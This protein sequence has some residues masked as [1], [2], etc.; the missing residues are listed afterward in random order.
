MKTYRYDHDG[1]PIAHEPPA[2]DGT[3]SLLRAVPRFW[4]RGHFVCERCSLIFIGILEM[5]RR[6]RPPMRM[7]CPGCGGTSAVPEA[8]WKASAK[9]SC[10]CGHVW[11]EVYTSMLHVEPQRLRCPSCHEYTDQIEAWP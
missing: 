7:G 10:N 4:Y 8:H 1:L 2:D 9:A 6:E 5:E 11:C 3:I